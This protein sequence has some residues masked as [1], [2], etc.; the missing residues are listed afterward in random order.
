LGLRLG[1][2]QGLAGE[3]SDDL[4]YSQWH[5]ATYALG[6]QL[7]LPLLTSS[8]YPVVFKHNSGSL[9]F[10]HPVA[11]LQSC[12]FVGSTGRS[13]IALAGTITM[14]APS[15]TAP[16]EVANHAINQFNRTIVDSFSKKKKCGFNAEYRTSAL[17]NAPHVNHHVFDP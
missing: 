5:P 6:T 7:Q 3:N 14:L 16:R 12:D 2:V 1:R 10:V 4:T 15:R 13:A 17:I 8:Q 9:A 11:C